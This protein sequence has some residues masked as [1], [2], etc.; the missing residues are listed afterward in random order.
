VGGIQP[1]IPGAVHGRG[2]GNVGQ[3]DGNGQQRPLVGAGLRQQGV[4]LAEDVGR[5]A[6]G[7]GG[8]IFGHLAGQPDEAARHDR[9]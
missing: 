8:R 7:V 9:P 3:H 1:R 6:F 2:V 5:L 4:D